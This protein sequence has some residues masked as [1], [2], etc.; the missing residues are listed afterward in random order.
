[1]GV[2]PHSGQSLHYPSDIADVFLAREA[3][4]A[5]SQGLVALTTRPSDPYPT[6]PKPVLSQ[7]VET[8]FFASLST[9]E[10]RL[11]P[12]GIV[13]S[14]SFDPFELERPAWELV[15]FAVPM[16]FDVEHISR[17]SSTC[18]WTRSF[19][20]VTRRAESLEIVGIATPHSRQFLDIDILIRVLSPKPGIVAVYRGTS[21]V[22]RYERGV[23][24]FPP[25]AP[26]RGKH[27]PQ[28]DSIE[29]AVLKEH[30]SPPIL[31][32]RQFIE[33]IVLDMV[34]LG[35]GGLL[36]ILAPGEDPQPVIRES[37]RIEP[38]LEL[39]SAIFEMY[40][41][42]MVAHSDDQHRFSFVNGELEERPE[43]Q[44]EAHNSFLAEKATRRV[45]RLLAQIA[46]LTAVDG[47]VV[48]SHEFNVL[49]FGVKLSPSNDFKQL[50]V[51]TVNQDLGLDES[52]PL[53]LR[54]TRHRAAA[55]FAA[56][57]PERLSV[58][59]SQDGDAA[60]FQQVESKVVHWP[61]GTPLVGDEE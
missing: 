47:A 32:V 58:I 49:A 43:T 12:V 3:A 41:A 16:K 38:P 35:H 21:E 37:K 10:G 53:G 50:E 20:V 45:S 22:V 56:E 29:Q 36:A 30:A 61:L 52:W 59:V 40:E 1:M 18:E 57:H 17:L 7:L 28:L 55:V 27:R 8:M 46:R 4:R 34:R 26:L 15:R 31:G 14:D 9:E 48:M 44:D 5:R 25:P 6:P 60:T 42:Q 24:R 11:N 54:G 23:I 19:L 51:F 39:G 2:M 33:R 13:F